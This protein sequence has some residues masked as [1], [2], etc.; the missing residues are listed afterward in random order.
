MENIIEKQFVTYE[1]ALKLKELGFE[2]KFLAYY[3]TLDGN[4]YEFA[5]EEEFNFIDS[6][7]NIGRNFSLGAPLWQQAIS[8]LRYKYNIEIE[9]FKS[10]IKFYNGDELEKPH[11]QFNIDKA[12]E[13]ASD[14]IYQSIDD[15]LTYKTFE[16]ARKQAILEA[17]NIINNNKNR[18]ITKMSLCLCI[19]EQLCYGLKALFSEKDC[20]NQEI[21]T[22]NGVFDDGTINCSNTVN[23]TPDV[24][25]IILRPMS[26]ISK[27]ITHYGYNDNKPFTPLLHIAKLVKPNMDWEMSS[28]GNGAFCQFYN[29]QYIKNSFILIKYRDGFEVNNQKVYDLLNLLHFDTRNLIDSYD[30]ISTKIIDPYRT[31]NPYRTTY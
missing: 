28:D 31:I 13:H 4:N 6:D 11:Y 22:I 7:L 16:E 1:I 30:A 17:I 20:D 29:L 10:I 5:L 26:D 19:S 18:E 2:K 12:F 3:Y 8:F 23:A 15:N 9:V 25:K 27:E 21:G 24:F 14:Y